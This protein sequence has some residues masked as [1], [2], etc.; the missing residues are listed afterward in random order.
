[1]SV[2]WV[3]TAPDMVGSSQTVFCSVCVRF[4][5]RDEDTSPLLTLSN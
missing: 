2:P 4:K 1:V 5:R 3:M